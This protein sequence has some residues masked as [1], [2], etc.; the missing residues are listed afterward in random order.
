MVVIPT[1][2]SI[3]KED[4]KR[5]ELQLEIIKGPNKGSQF[6]FADNNFFLLGRNDKG[7]E[8]HYKL[9]PED[10]YVSRN[11]CIFEIKP[12]R[13]V[14]IDNHS[15]NGTDLKRNGENEFKQIKG[16]T[17]LRHG[18]QIQLGYTIIEV[19]VIEQDIKK[20]REGSIHEIAEEKEEKDNSQ[21][22]QLGAGSVFDGQS[23]IHCIKCGRNITELLK[24]KRTSQLNILDYRCNEC[25]LKYKST[26]I[27][28]MPSPEQ[29][30]HHYQKYVFQCTTCGANDLSDYA[31]NDGR[32]FELY[33][34]ASYLCKNCYEKELSAK[35]SRAIGDYVILD[36]LGEGGM[37]IVYRAR[38]DP[39]GRIVAIKQIR[40]EYE[41]DEYI[42]KR[43]QR[44]IALTSMLIHNNV[45]RLYDIGYLEKNREPYLVTE[46]V[47]GGNAED[48]ILKG[49]RGPIPINEACDIICQTLCGL[50]YIH[51]DAVEKKG[52]IHRDITSRNILLSY[53]RN[54]Y[55]RQ[56]SYGNDN[57]HNSN[58]NDFIAKLG[59]YGLA[60]LVEKLG[61]FSLNRKNEVWGTPLYMSPEQI[62]NYH[63]VKP[64]SDVYSVAITLYY[65]LTSKYPFNFPSP[66]ELAQDNDG[67]LKKELRH[68]KYH[69]ERLKEPHFMV[70]EDPRIA[71]RDINPSI[72]KQLA[73]IIDTAIEKEE[74]DRRPFTTARSLREAIQNCLNC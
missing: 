64:P 4:D 38:H 27:E 53:T 63:Y 69:G 11:H 59:D 12:P 68:G 7:S 73:S 60:R 65:L 34:I 19:S 36:I 57:D 14:I 25:K 74:Q 56:K 13:C 16:P 26:L 48:L 6:R 51:S 72:P 28:S 71:I 49:Y 30:K 33:N 10:R 24:D 50:E 1:M 23:E 3:H 31:N 54:S 5:M 18:D 41:K 67:K 37:G 52:I 62:T 58:K 46:Y 42:M 55:Y 61:T 40:P 66:L 9:S 29:R 21:R 47:A 43:F 39:T 70:L 32:A 15:L 35:A 17:E 20:Q 2:N 8:A 44:E 45:V 22:Q